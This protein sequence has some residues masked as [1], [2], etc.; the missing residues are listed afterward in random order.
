MVP[1]LPQKAVISLRVITAEVFAETCYL[2]SPALTWHV[3]EMEMTHAPAFIRRG[4]ALH[5]FSLSRNLIFA[6]TSRDS[7]PSHL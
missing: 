3:F 5:G 2:Q 7:L 1:F 4:L 6:L